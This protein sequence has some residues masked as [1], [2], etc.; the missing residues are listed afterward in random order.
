ME[1]IETKLSGAFLVSLQKIEDRRGF[2][3]RGWC[4]DEF[5]EH[6]L[7]S[8]MTQ[9]NVGFSHRRGTLRGLHY[10]VP[11]HQEAK[12]IRCT[13][14]AIFDVIVDLRPDSP[15]RG[16]WF[17]AELTDE[18]ALMVYVPEGFAHGY[19]TLTDNTETYYLTSARYAAS[20]AR[21]VRYNEPA[22]GI[23]WP[24]P[25]SVVSD[26]DAGWPDY[27]AE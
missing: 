10:Q 16:R 8:D 12:L 2:F 25:V 5:S 21:G 24:L 26:A 23:S 17:G 20:A 18:N 1:F 6:G 4:R 3:A 14:G 27:I 9:L 13:R 22:F 15:T 19:Q 11:P 7:T